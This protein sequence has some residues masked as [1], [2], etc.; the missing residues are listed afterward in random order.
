[1][2]LYDRRCPNGHTTTVLVR[3]DERDEPVPCSA[4]GAHTDRLFPLSHCPPSG[5]FSYAPN[6]G[7]P[8]KFERHQAMI[9]GEIKE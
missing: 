6:M 1:M 9:K 7:D 4:C 5:V 3:Y 2:P 8:N